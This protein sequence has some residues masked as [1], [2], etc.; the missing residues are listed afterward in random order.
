MSPTVLVRGQGAA[1]DEAAH[2]AARLLAGARCPV[3]AGLGTCAAGA[4]AAAALA[5]ACGGVLDHAHSDALL[6]DL[7]AMREY[8]WIVA[9]P[10]LARARADTVLLVGPGLGEFAMPP[11]PALDPGRARRVLRF[12]PTPLLPV[13][14]VLRALA[15]GRPVADHADPGGALA[16][17]ALDLQQARYGV[18]AWSAEAMTEMEVEAL[19]GLISDLNA[20]TRW[21]GL[22][23]PAG[24]N[25][26]GVVQALGWTTGFPVRVGF[27]RGRAEHDPWRF[28]AARL[29][30]SGEADALVW[31]Q[32]ME[33][34]PPPWKRSVPLVA[35]TMPGVQFAH[36]P[37]V[38]VTV[39]QPG[40]DHDA[41][42]FNAESGA[43]V[44]ARAEAA[45]D[46]PTV[47]GVLGAIT[48]ALRERDALC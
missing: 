44:A 46:A 28:S 26:N 15:A 43:L 3:I 19:C 4:E 33:T 7:G 31:V 34:E 9:T 36:P 13:L 17:L 16:Q 18:A 32:A 39:G 48:K 20:G 35:L 2:A 6:R 8:G 21:A 14:G 5:E 1:L 12:A 25:A 38:A 47:A 42:L 22:P 30:E 40:M 45:S 29:I 27:G 11:A 24:A 23:V 41:V 10:M 37:E